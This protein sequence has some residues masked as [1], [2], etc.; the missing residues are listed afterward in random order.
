MRIESIDNLFLTTE[1]DPK[2]MELVNEFASVQQLKPTTA[3]KR[4]LLRNLPKAIKSE[5]DCQEQK[6]D[7]GNAL[8]TQPVDG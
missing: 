4:F 8:Q 7:N 6:T 3:I 5:V 2:L 1:R